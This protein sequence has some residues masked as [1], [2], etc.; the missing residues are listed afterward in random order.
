M[1]LEQI[2][3]TLLSNIRFELR[4]DIILYIVIRVWVAG[5]R[6]L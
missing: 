6:V 2:G 3:Y 5:I 4:T 1:N